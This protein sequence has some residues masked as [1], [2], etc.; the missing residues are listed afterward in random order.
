M[1]WKAPV[2]HIPTASTRAAGQ[3]ESFRLGPDNTCVI[4]DYADRLRSKAQFGRAIEMLRKT[5]EAGFREDLAY[6]MA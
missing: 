2:I 5:L 6:V 1:S 3:Q 4:R